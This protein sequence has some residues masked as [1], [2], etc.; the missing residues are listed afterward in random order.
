MTKKELSAKVAE[1]SGV[2][3]KTVEHILNIERDVIVETLKEGEAVFSR[4]FGSFAIKT[5]APRQARNIHQG[6]VID[7]PEKKV[8]KFKASFN[9]N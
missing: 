3:V 2:D 7:V 8:V 1:V 5:R 4:G 9:L 6:T